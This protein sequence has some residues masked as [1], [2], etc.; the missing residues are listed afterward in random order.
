MSRL[1][2]ILIGALLFC[3]NAWAEDSVSYR[4]L[5]HQNNENSSRLSLG[6]T[7]EQVLDTMG[8]VSSSVPDGPISNP[9]KSEAFLHEG[10]PVEVLYYLVRKHPPF[11][12]LSESQAISVVIKS[13]SVVAW[14]RNAQ[15]PFK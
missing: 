11:A 12:P 5:L 9:W 13:G 10:E 6:M 4:K 1:L 8:A 15:S 7:K 2:S 3:G 14:G